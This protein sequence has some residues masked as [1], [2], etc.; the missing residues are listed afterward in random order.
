M[1][2]ESIWRGMKIRNWGNQQMYLLP[3]VD[4]GFFTIETSQ[5]HDSQPQPAKNF[6]SVTF[7]PPRSRRVS[8]RWSVFRVS[9]NR[10]TGPHLAFQNLGKCRSLCQSLRGVTES[11]SKSQSDRWKKNVWT[12][13]EDLIESVNLTAFFWIIF[14]LSCLSTINK[15]VKFE[16]SV[17]HHNSSQFYARIFS[18]TMYLKK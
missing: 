10:Q 15:F 16:E 6:P 12:S 8:I 2:F 3:A 1:Q 18:R 11:R 5:F 17:V 14:D 4:C 9:T 13:T 7:L